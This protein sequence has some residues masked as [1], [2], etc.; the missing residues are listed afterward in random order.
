MPTKARLRANTQLP[1]VAL[2]TALILAAWAALLALQQPLSPVGHL[3]GH[4]GSHSHA[5]APHL[6]LSLPSFAAFAVSW[7]LMILAMMLPGALPFIARLVAAG[8]QQRPRRQRYPWGVA[9]FVA[10]YVGVWLVFGVVADLGNQGMQELQQRIAQGT[11]MQ[12][13]PGALLQATLVIA[14]LYQFTPTKQHATGGSCASEHLIAAPGQDDAPNRRAFVLGMRYG[15]QC[16]GCCWALMLLMV[17]GGSGV[18]H[19]AGPML[20]LGAIMTLEKN[21]VWA[22]RLSRSLGG[23]LIGMALILAWADVRGILLLPLHTHG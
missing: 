2:L 7:T 23:F 3:L 21:S 10:G 15:W 9:L 11:G 1:I 8:Q 19:Q 20:V 12:V 22:A 5:G 4:G 6:E 14:G 18:A 16:L 13:G 17:A